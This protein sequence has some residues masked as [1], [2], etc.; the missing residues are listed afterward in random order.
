MYK[1]TGF[2]A[3]EYAVTNE[4]IQNWIGSGAI[5]MI[6]VQMTKESL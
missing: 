5:E 3:K 4:T 6:H 1:S 2:L